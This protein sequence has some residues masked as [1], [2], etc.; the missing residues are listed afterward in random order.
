MC[1]RDS[2]LVVTNVTA[3]EGARLHS[4]P[5]RTSS[6]L[7]TAHS[8]R[9]GEVVMSEL[10]IAFIILNTIA[11]KSLNRYISFVFFFIYIRFTCVCVCMK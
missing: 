6:K 4:Y 8:Q 7:G 2:L 10:S 9:D 3:M 1:I 11:S 5:D